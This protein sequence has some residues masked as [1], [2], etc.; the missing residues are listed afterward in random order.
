MLY[1]NYFAA[2]TKLSCTR[3][4]NIALRNSDCCQEDADADGEEGEGGRRRRRRKRRKKEISPFACFFAYK[5]WEYHWFWAWQ[6]EPDWQ[7]VA[8][9]HP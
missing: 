3:T 9:V 7:Q 8:P 6:V 5:H 4:S 2:K 1:V